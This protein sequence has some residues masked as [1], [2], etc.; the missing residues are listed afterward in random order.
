[1]LSTIAISLHGNWW[2]RRFGEERRSDGG[3]RPLSRYLDGVAAAWH[4]DSAG[5]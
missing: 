5:K 4:S 2:K 3:G 1:V